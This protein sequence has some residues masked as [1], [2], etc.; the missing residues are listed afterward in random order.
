MH[1]VR[2]RLPGGS[3]LVTTL[4][5]WEV[6]AMLTRSSQRT[7]TAHVRRRPILGVLILLALTHHWFIEEPGHGRHCTSTAGGVR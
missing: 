6:Y 3:I 5:T 4:C 2:R 7:I 1:P